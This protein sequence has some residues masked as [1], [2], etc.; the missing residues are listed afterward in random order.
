MKALLT[1]PNSDRC[2]KEVH[3]DGFSWGALF[4]GFFWYWIHGMWSKG[5]IYLL[6]SGVAYLS[7]IGI[8]ILW[9]WMAVKFREEY[10]GHL[11]EK[12]YKDKKN[13]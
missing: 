8:P 6:V 5:L 12:G 3:R 2:F 13:K 4:F 10:Y 9:I 1:H 7:I 11:I